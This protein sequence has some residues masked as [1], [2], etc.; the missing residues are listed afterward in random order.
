L[1]IGFL[2]LQF[3]TSQKTCFFSQKAVPKQRSIK[4]VPADENNPACRICGEAFKKVFDQKVDEWM[5]MGAVYEDGR[6]SRGG[7]KKAIVHQQCF[8]DAMNVEVPKP[9]PSPKSNALNS[10]LG[11]PKVQLKKRPKPDDSDSE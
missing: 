9:Q 3:Q 7:R 11:L 2:T 6:T 4:K 1:K 5:Y 8:E 10:V